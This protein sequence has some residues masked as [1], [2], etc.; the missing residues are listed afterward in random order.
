[1]P[2]DRDV[3]ASINILHRATTLGQRGRHAQGEAVRPQKKAPLEE[4]RTDKTHP[5]QDAV[6]A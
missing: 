6:I 4:L 1:M 2:K 3:N 5:L